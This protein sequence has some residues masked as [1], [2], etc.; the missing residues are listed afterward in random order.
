MNYSLDFPSVDSDHM[1]K[2]TRSMGITDELVWTL[3]SERTLDAPDLVDDYNLNLLD[4]GSNNVL[5]IA[6]GKTLYL[7]DA[8]EG[9]TSELMTVD[10][11][12]RPVTSVKW[13]PDGRH[14]SIVLNN[15]DIHLWPAISQ[16]WQRQSP[17]YLGPIDVFRQCSDPIS[18][19]SRGP[20][21]GGQ[22][23]RLVPLPL[24]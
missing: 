13:A 1:S 16:R 14:I 17:S 19:L 7:W 22:S 21:D 10:D 11:E 15:S 2:R 23:P 24:R 3:T 8:S 18:S 12:V 20:P 9:N 4:W 6:L 5:A